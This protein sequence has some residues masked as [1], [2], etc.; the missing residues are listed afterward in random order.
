MS[1]IVFERDMTWKP[2]KTRNT[3]IAF[4][5]GLCVFATRQ[6]TAIAI[7]DKRAARLATD[8]EI[9]AARAKERG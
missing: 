1:W 7:N 4:K 2:V 6:A 3:Q 5:A 9:A 8:A